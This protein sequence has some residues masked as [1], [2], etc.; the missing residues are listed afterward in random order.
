MI[1]KAKEQYPQTNC[2]FLVGDIRNFELDEKVDLVFSNA[3]MHWVPKQDTRESIN[4][5][6]KAL[7]DGGRYVA[8]FG[9]KGN[10]ESL[11]SS[12]SDALL[13]MKGVEF[14]CPWYFPSI[15]EYT[16]ALEREGFE[17]VSAE[18]F[19]RPTV[20]ESGYDGLKNWFRTFATEFLSDTISSDDEFSEL[21][22]RVE[23]D[24]KPKMYDGENWT[25]DY[26][27]IRVAAF[28]I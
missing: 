7:V 14:A 17:V 3:A 21:M 27:R 20:L 6:R 4:S 16:N 5:I 8:E 12:C 24:L 2:T 26:R 28:K 13:S 25:A 1:L 9:G 22:R 11:V 10:V 18:L 23:D 15:S 19:D